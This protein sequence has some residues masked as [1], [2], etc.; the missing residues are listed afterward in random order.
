MLAVTKIPYL[1][2]MIAS[3]GSDVAPLALTPS[4][5]TS[6]GKEP[7][8]LFEKSRRRRPRCLVYLTCAVIDLGG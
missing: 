8:T 1:V 3:L 2:Q 7:A 4:S 6:V 5:F